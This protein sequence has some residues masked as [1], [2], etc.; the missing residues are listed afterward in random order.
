MVLGLF[1]CVTHKGKVTFLSKPFLHNKETSNRTYRG[2]TKG[3]LR[4]ALKVT[5]SIFAYE[6]VI[7]SQT[8]VHPLS[9]GKEGFSLG[10]HT[11]SRGVSPLLGLFIRMS[12]KSRSN[13]TLSESDSQLANTSSA[14]L[15]D[16]EPQEKDLLQTLRPTLGA[17]EI[18]PVP[19]TKSIEN[20][21]SLSGGN[22]DISSENTS[23]K[24]HTTGRLLTIALLSELK[25]ASNMYTWASSLKDTLTWLAF[26]KSLLSL[27]E[28]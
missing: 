26:K 4:G 14:Q 17:A 24:P 6:K 20:S 1:W 2:S 28:G 5:F 19:G 15:A 7:K 13:Q 9:L 11:L 27:T 23:G 25:E 12:R 10:K 16:S 22:L 3:S 21:I 18:G 8:I